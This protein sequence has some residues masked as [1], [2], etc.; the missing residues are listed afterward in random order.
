MSTEAVDARVRRRIP[1]ALKLAASVSLLMLGCVCVLAVFL[2]NHQSRLIQAHA[3]DF[4]TLITEQ[5][6]STAVEPLF[7]DERY[8]LEALVRHIASNERILGAAIFTRDGKQVALAGLVPGFDL[9]DPDK[10]YQKLEPDQQPLVAGKDFVRAAPVSVHIEPIKF[11]GVLAGYAVASYS[12]DAIVRGY[13]HSLKLLAL[14]TGLMMVAMCLVVFSLG[15]RVTRPLNALVR[16]TQAIDRGDFTEI[17]ERRND[18]FGQ[19]INAVNQMGQGL[20]N[21]SQ[22]EGVMGQLLAKDVAAQVL[23]KLDTIQVG[24]EQVEATVLFA[25]IVGF[26]EISES[27]SPREVSELLNEYFTYLDSCARFYFGTID[28][29]IGD[30]VMVVFGS[31][32][33]DP[34]HQYHAVSCAVLMQKLIQRLNQ[35][36][37]EK[38]QYTV[39]LRIGINSGKMLAGLLGSNDRLEYTV[40]GDSVNIA[41]RLC[42]EAAS[43]QIIIQ[44]SLYEEIRQ[45]HNLCVEQHEKIKLRGKS[46]P[47][48]VYNVYAVEQAH[49][50]AMENLIED[51]ISHRRAA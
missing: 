41:S 24:G 39:H 12:Q 34:A 13:K 1:I 8:E 4:S 31:P 21:R 17:E 5:L 14:I 42:N 37:L 11:K 6:A 28:K 27:L 49:P 15:K 3:D 44:D 7:T 51:V 32:K 48:T 20:L 22:V 40:V 18:E 29:Y 38:G 46:K 43:G 23:N 9:L 35:Q 47:V 19:L 16:A 50:M 25:D 10:P 2:L 30:C 36:R 45:N 33:P 26:T